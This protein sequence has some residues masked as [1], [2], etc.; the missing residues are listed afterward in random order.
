MASFEWNRELK[1]WT[2]QCPS[3]SITYKVDGEKWNDAYDNFR[4]NFS[5]DSRTKDGLYSFCRECQNYY[6]RSKIDNG[7]SRMEMAERQGHKCAICQEPFDVMH[8]N[9]IYVDHDHETGIIRELLCAT[10]NRSM[11]AVDDEEWLAK[12]IVYRNKHRS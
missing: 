3:C 1:V 6:R 11:A 7:L 12:A 2:K 4:I 5:P 9:R 8:R 10:C